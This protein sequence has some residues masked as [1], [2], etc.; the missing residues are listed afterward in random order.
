M[1]MTLRRRIIIAFV[2]MVTVAVVLVGGISYGATAR[3]VNTER[4]RSLASAAATLAAGGTVSTI[5]PGPG[6]GPGPGNNGDGHGGADGVVT[7]ARH[8]AP[9]GTATQL[10]GASVDLPI[11]DLD[12]R[13]ASTATAG[14]GQY[15]F[16][17]VDQVTYRTYTLAQGGGNGAVQVAR[18]TADGDRVLTTIAMLTLLIGVAV[19]LLAVAAAWW[20][21]RQITRRLEELSTAAEYVTSTGD[22]SVPIQAKGNDEVG[23]LGQALRSML[24]QLAAAKDAQLRLVQNASHELRTPLTSLRTN[25]QVLRRFDELSPSSRTRLLDDVDGELFELTDLVDE[26]VE[27]AGDQRTAEPSEATDLGEIAGAC[28]D[29]VG[30]RTGRRIAVDTDHAVVTV[31]RQAIERAMTNLLENAV[32][33]DHDGT[34]PIELVARRD[35]VEVLDRG[36]GLPEAD[37]ERIFDRFYRTDSAR[38]LPGSGLG[39][40]I[41][42]EVAQTHGGS[43]MARNRLGGGAIIGFTLPADLAT[44]DPKPDSAGA[45]LPNSNSQPLRG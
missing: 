15:E 38:S 45:V 20:T 34:A 23:R 37:A 35:R 40:S 1:V 7:T 4:D 10:L 9:D 11:T 2:L 6:P 43:V 28:A 25:A 39:L 44:A 8:I 19:I 42:R 31:R 27:L 22:L 26:L 30:R 12:R 18:D 33:F 29:R 32:K 14:S 36:P 24:N 41:V 21:A 13:L 3:T 5:D 16:A 17:T